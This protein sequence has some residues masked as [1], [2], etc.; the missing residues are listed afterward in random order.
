M[1]IK[2]YSYNLIN[3][4]LKK[5][6]FRLIT[7]KTWETIEECLTKSISINADQLSEKRI[8][9]L[10]CI[11]FSKDRPL[12]LFSLLE[13]LSINLTEPIEITI[14]YK[15]TNERFEKSY[16]DLIEE[17]NIHRLNIN[18]V[19]ENEEFKSLLSKI[20]K[21]VNTNKIFFLTD[22]NIALRPINISQIMDVASKCNILSLRHS[23]NITVS[24]N[25][26]MKNLKPVLVQSCSNKNLIKFKWFMEKAEWSDPYSLDGH[27]YSTNHIQSL[28]NISEFRAPNSLESS[29]KYYNFLQINKVSYCFKKSLF[30]NIP[31]N[32]TQSEWINKSEGMSIYHALEAWEKNLKFK[33]LD[34]KEYVPKSTHEIIN[35]NLISRIN[36]LH[37]P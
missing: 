5:F 11:I 32:L 33:I 1:N 17:I 18:W 4:I 29:L 3:T 20:L 12:Q 36:K 27:V 25:T 31:L 22:D 15:V 35:L 30:V 9:G 19:Q 24:Y 23:P 37:E 10:S 13:T 6:N 8:K 26:S 7:N 2:E 28:I 14:I 21:K 16:L 34:L